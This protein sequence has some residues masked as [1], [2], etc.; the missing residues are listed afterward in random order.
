MWTRRLFDLGLVACLM[1]AAAE[2][3]AAPPATPPFAPDEDALAVYRGQFK[4][5]IDRYKAGALAEAIGYWD[6]I[7]RELG[8]QQGYRLAYDLGIAYQESGDATHAAERLQSFLTEVEARRERGDVLASI[9]EKEEADARQRIASLTASTGRIHVGAVSAPRTARVDAREPRIAGFVAWVA[10]GDHTVTFAAGTPD[11]ET[12]RIH[13]GPGEMVEVTPRPPPPP[14]PPPEPIIVRMPAP[15]PRVVPAPQ[16]R[17]PFPWPLIAVSG[18]AALV[19]AV[20]AVP[21]YNNAGALYDRLSVEPSIPQSDRDNYNRA[22]TTAYSVAGAAIGLAALT[23]G[24][25][26]WYF[27]GTSEGEGVT[28]SPAFVPAPGGV[29][30]GAAGRF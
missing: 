8:E 22:R 3:R 15:A 28:V 2:A 5:G 11:A 25:A 12:K 13:V 20:V 4:R 18:G 27:L 1:L 7:Y 16:M 9:V 21:L 24:L 26:A 23:A 14:P 29:S 30:F 19:T 6:P 17:H 10:P